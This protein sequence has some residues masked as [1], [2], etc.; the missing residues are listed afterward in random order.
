MKRQTK[1]KGRDTATK[2]GALDR[3]LR[4]YPASCMRLSMRIFRQR[5]RIDLCHALVAIL[6]TCHAHT[7]PSIISHNGTT[8]YSLFPGTEAVL[9]DRTEATVA[10]RNWLPEERYG[11]VPYRCQHFG[12][13]RLWGQGAMGWCGFTRTIGS[14]SR[15]VDKSE[16]EVLPCCCC[17]KLVYKF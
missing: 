5:E 9:E 6:V 2:C 7:F 13:S 17:L 4:M 16:P 8:R 12:A 15:H 11:T 1:L 10:K 3:T 14:G